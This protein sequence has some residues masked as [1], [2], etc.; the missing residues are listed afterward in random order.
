M[1]NILKLVNQ[2]TQ[3]FISRYEIHYHDTWCTITYVLHITRMCVSIY[4]HCM[5]VQLSLCRLS[6]KKLL[7]LYLACMHMCVWMLVYTGNWMCVNSQEAKERPTT[8]IQ[9]PIQI[10]IAYNTWSH[11]NTSYI[12]H[13]YII[14]VPTMSHPFFLYIYIQAIL[15][16]HLPQ[17]T[18]FNIIKSSL[19]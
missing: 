17:L 8:I 12:I 1:S 9:F 2:D 11:Q 6:R 5:H 15:Y 7:L 13:T 14:T 19:F 18:S 10:S 16:L 3:N 4:L